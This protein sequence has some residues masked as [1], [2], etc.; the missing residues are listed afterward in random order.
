MGSRRLLIFLLL[1]PCVAFAE[2]KVTYTKDTATKN[3][4]VY[5]LKKK[6]QFAEKLANEAKKAK[7]KKVENRD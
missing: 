6:S 1:L 2:D 4:V 5:R 3:G 7:E